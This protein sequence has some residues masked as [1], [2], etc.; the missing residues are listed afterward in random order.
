MESG[1]RVEEGRK[2][3]ISKEKKEKKNQF[4]LKN[5]EPKTQRKT[6]GK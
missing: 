1:R 6:P 4:S 5:S 2:E 3:K